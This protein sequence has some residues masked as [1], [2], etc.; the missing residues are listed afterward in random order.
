MAG[1]G[2]GLKRKISKSNF[3]LMYPSRMPV[4][5]IQTFISSLKDDDKNS[6][7]KLAAKEVGAFYIRD[8]DDNKSIDSEILKI[9]DNAKEEV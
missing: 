3:V 1:F 9:I 8:R 4:F 2:R 7:S 6:L 5:P